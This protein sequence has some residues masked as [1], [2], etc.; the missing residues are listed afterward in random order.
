MQ[1][2]ILNSKTFWVS[3]LVALAPLVPGLR[4][5]ITESPEVFSGV[6]GAIFAGLRMITHGKVVLL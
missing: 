3:L 5:W 4:E 1:K 2:S 6:I